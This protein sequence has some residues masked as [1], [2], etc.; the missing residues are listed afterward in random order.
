MQLLSKWINPVQNG[1][2]GLDVGSGAVKLLALRSTSSGWTAS[3]AA[4]AE[5]QP[6]NDKATR[7]ADTLEAVRS[8]FSQVPRLSVRYTVCGL[9]SPDAAVRA[10][11]FPTLPD[12][13]VEQAVRFEAQQVCP[14]DMRHSVIDYQMLRQL[15]ANA[16]EAKTQSGVM[17]AGAEQAVSERCRL[18]REA[19]A[20]VALMD[21]DGLAALNCLAELEDLDRFQTVA[22]IDLGWNYTNIILLGPNGLPFERDINS[23]IKDILSQVAEKTS[24]DVE[25]VRQT[26]WAA[27]K[28]LMPD[29]VLVAFH[30]AAR[31]LIMNVNE[32][33][34]FYASQEKCAFS[35]KVYLCGGAAMIHPLVELLSDALPTDVAVFDPF[36]AIRFDSAVKGAELMKTRGPAFVV[37]AGLA[38]RT[39]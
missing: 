31:Q 25:T 14:I 30:H 29:D 20:K 3:G 6:S 27:D 39:V 32:T 24:R 18:V 37:A 7:H 19:G 12:N 22:L 1:L 2:V 8:C 9:S 33:L 21:A 38:M 34:K 5:I 35:E 26:L 4:W 11:T 10:F 13:A 23:G 16:D 28:T 36:K 17:V 15:E